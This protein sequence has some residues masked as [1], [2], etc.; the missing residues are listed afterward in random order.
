MKSH[1]GVNPPRVS[2]VLLRFP[3]VSFVVNK[4]LPGFRVCISD[5]PSRS[6]STEIMPFTWHAGLSKHFPP[7]ASVE[8]LP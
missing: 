6:F 7:R 2:L 4:T 1:E 3:F 8:C 5:L